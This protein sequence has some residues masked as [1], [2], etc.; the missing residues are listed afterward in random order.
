M[1]RTGPCPPLRVSDANET[2]LSCKW[3]SMFILHIYAGYK[4]EKHAGRSIT[5]Q[6]SVHGKARCFWLNAPLLCILVRNATTEKAIR[7]FCLDSAERMQTKLMASW[8]PIDHNRWHH[9]GLTW[10]LF[11]GKV[12]PGQHH[13]HTLMHHASPPLY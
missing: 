3:S 11:G 2:T 13:C 12:A 5:V 8:W 7:A 10:K 9:L 6:A 4:R 1:A